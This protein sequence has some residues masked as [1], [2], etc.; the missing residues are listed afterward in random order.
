LQLLEDRLTVLVLRLLGHRWP[1]QIEAGEPVPT[2]AD[3]DGIIPLVAG[4][5]SRTLAELVR[6]RL[7]AEDGAVSAQQVENLLEELT[8]LT[9]EQWLRTRFFDHHISQFKHRPI[10]WHLAST[11]LR[12][13]NKIDAGKG[14]NK[15]KAGPA[16]QRMPAFE[17]FLYYHACPGD[18]LARIRTQ[19]VEPLIQQERVTINQSQTLL[20]GV[21]SDDTLA[22]IARERIRELE[23]FTEKLRRVEEQAFACPELIK[24]VEGEP[25]DRWSGDGLEA[26]SSSA[27]LRRQEESWQVDI[28]DGVRVNIAPL[29]LF[30]VLTKDV[31]NTKDARKAIADRV[32]WR[33]DERRW[34]REGKLP[35]CGWMDNRVP[36]SPAWDCLAGQRETEQLR[37]AQKRLDLQTNESEEEVEA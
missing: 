23:A 35:R 28:N 18:T 24:V 14:N 34:V 17:C 30:G 13:S 27:G 1:K 4:T 6:E 9:L 31:L 20:D 8:K 26:L 22:Q 12:G 5:G 21:A 15:K 36:A 3:S 11:P 29:Q 16:G 32:R 7:Y 33:A 10:A 25:L 19:Y 37:L 2:W